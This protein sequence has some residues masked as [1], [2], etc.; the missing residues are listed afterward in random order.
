VT[1]RPPP[2]RALLDRFGGEVVRIPFAVAV[3]DGDPYRVIDYVVGL[4]I[5]VSQ[6]DDLLRINELEDE[7]ELYA[8]RVVEG[9]AVSI[10]SDG[11]WVLFEA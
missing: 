8:H 11:Y 5:E 2:L 1:L 3:R 10:M 6:P 9:I 7:E 4:G